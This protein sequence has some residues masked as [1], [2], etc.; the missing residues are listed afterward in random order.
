MLKFEFAAVARR[1]RRSV[2]RGRLLSAVAIATACAFWVSPSTANLI[3][4]D[5]LFTEA[6]SGGPPTESSS[7]PLS[8]TGTECFY[9]GACSSDSAET[10]AIGPLAE[11]TANKTLDGPEAYGEA[12]VRYEFEVTGTTQTDVPLILFGSTD[13]KE[14]ISQGAVLAS[15]KIIVQGAGFSEFVL[16]GGLGPTVF[17]N[18]FMAESNEVSS[19]LLDALCDISLGD[20]TC[21]AEI[22]PLIEIAPSFLASNPGTELVLSPNIV[23]RA[24][25]AI[26]EPSTW[27]MLALGFAALAWAGGRRRR[28]S[29][30]SRC[31]PWRA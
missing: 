7:I 26:P 30:P 9:L 12:Q 15:A 8:Q 2:A 24:P 29:L 23:Q 4:E 18:T 25:S 1:V 27:A 6:A 14:V 20:G 16:T 28:L 13:I 11:A 10:S 19:I 17:D 31:V 5:A 22:D 3:L 21:S